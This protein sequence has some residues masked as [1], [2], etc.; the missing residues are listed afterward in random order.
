[1]PAYR[2]TRDV[3][4]I[5]REEILPWLLM[6][7][8][9]VE[10]TDHSEFLQKVCGDFI[11]SQITKTYGIELKAERNSSTGNLFL[12][13]WS[14]REWRT[15]GWMIT[16]Q[17]DWLFYYFLDTQTL[18]VINLK[19]LQ[20][21]AFGANGQDGAIYDWPEKPQS[22][23]VQRNDTWGRCVP[24]TEIQNAG[25]PMKIFTAED[26]NLPILN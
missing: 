16:S 21:W 23:Y 13:T 25:I 20:K 6:K 8:D 9:A 12:E 17:A 7:C 10:D 1:M 4:R 14:N 18:Y 22:R 2:Q 11:V 5:A 19:A 24:I 26:R 3:E 15:P